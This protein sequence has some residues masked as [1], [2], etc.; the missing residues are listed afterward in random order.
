M[1]TDQLLARSALIG[2]LLLLALW[3]G[4]FAS[5]VRALDLSLGSAVPANALAS[6]PAALQPW[7]DWVLYDQQDRRC[8]VNYDAVD[9]RQC[10][11]PSAL[12][13]TL[14]ARGGQ[15]SQKIYTDRESWLI[16]PGDRRHWPQEVRLD[17]LLVPVLER[18]DRPAIK[19][20]PGA[21]QI[22]GRFVWRALPDSIRVPTQNALLELRIDGR[23]V[24]VSRIESDGVLWLR[25]RPTEPAQQDDLDLQVF[26]LLT[27][28]IP[29]EVET[30]LE[31]RVSGQ[32]REEMLGP[33]LLPDFLPLALN[34]PLPARLEPDGRLRVQ[35]RPGSWTINLTAR[36]RGPVDALARPTI[37]T[38]WPEQEIWSFRAQNALRV[39]QVSGA[40]ALDPA[41]TR[42]PEAWRQWPAYLV[43]PSEALRFAT[44]TRG[45]TESIPESLTLDRTLWL[46]FGGG[47]YTV[48]DRLS[49]NLNR[50]RL[51][52]APALKLGRVE[53]NG[54]DQF[55]TQS[56]DAGAT[57]VEVRRLN[58]LQLVAD[59]RLELAAASDL[60][61]VGWR[62]APQH[63]N[64]TLNLPPGWRLLAA[65][66]PDSTGNAWL[67]SWNL[68]DL[69]V[70]L[71]IAFGFGKLW[72][73]LWGIAALLGM[74]L[75]YHEPN[76][77]LYVWL[78]ILAA[79]ALLRVL[80]PGRFRVLIGVYRRL[81]LLALLVI[82]AL[83]AVQQVRSALY[84]QLEP[85]DFDEPPLIGLAAF[86][87]NEPMPQAVEE[88]QAY[89]RAPSSVVP[90]KGDRSK[91]MQQQYAPDIKVQ[92]GPGLP[93]WNWQRATLRWNGPV[94]AD[95]RLQLW[96]LPPWGTRLLLLLGLALLAAMGG[97]VFVAGQRNTDP[98]S[99]PPHDGAEPGDIGSPGA[100]AAV[101]SLL[102]AGL[103]LGAPLAARAEWPTPE[104]LET[105]RDRL[106]EPPDCQRCGDLAALAL[107]AKGGDL[108]L[109]L[110]LHA[111]VDTAVPLPLPRE[112][113]IVRAVELDG[114]AAILL[115]DPAQ[116]LWLRLPA[117]LHELTV[118]AAVPDAVAT[119][120]LPL[121]MAP[122]RVELDVEGW[123]VEGYIEGRADKQ[124][125]LTRQRQT[126]ATPLQA[127]VMP[128]FV[129][130]EREI[131]LDVDWQIRTRV[132]RL[133]QA[134]SA[135]V[136]EIPLLP[137]ERVTT[138]DVRVRDGR[139]LL[140]LPPDRA[141]AVWNATLSRSD[142]L[143]LKAAE[144]DDFVEVWQLRAGSLWH[145][146]STGIPLVQR[147]DAEGQWL[148]EWRPWPGEQVT[149]TI[150]RPEGAPGGTATI[151]RSQLQLN[152]GQRLSEAT[153]E[154]TVRASRG[155]DQTVT[156]PAGA[157]LTSVRVNDVQQP[158]QQ[159]GQQVVLPL[160][161]GVQ[162]IVLVWR[163]EQGIGTRYETPVVDLGSPSVNATLSVSLPRN[164]WVLLAG[165]PVMG[166]AVLFWG[167]L[168]VILV[169]AIVLARVGGTPL[170]VH[171]WFLL[172]VGLSQSHVLA[173][174]VVAGW[175][176]LLAR[177][178]HWAD[179]EMGTFKFDLAQLALALL[180]LVAGAVLLGAIEQGLLGSPD[181]QIAGNHSSAWQLN[182]YQ[183][184]VAG[185]LP[186]AW[187]MSAPML[188]Y[189][190]LMLA[191]ALWLALAI[192]RWLGWAWSCFSAGGLWRR[193]R[194][195]H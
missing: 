158:I 19:A 46:D 6:I 136:V 133:S 118:T 147:V 51:D 179:R 28:G 42:L 75:I 45:D 141:E 137:G 128:P 171:E 1:R 80:P 35:L 173:I 16:L 159:Q 59:S 102:L 14:D 31:L 39:V 71:V 27:D 132:R 86:L 125:Q 178:K 122:G 110:S 92:T 77:P 64:A 190:G 24:A 93:V 124:L 160:T 103:L 111:Q 90:R 157:I 57:G 55:I 109:R 36:H 5:P 47:G 26:R 151:D 108:T 54:E 131:V 15:F 113:L 98:A 130:V 186:T 99:Q 60:A 91:K 41:Q 44:R 56:S 68:L 67:Y 188:L 185:S 53:I 66:G 193:W 161:P 184:R 127:G 94:A 76:A 105:L 115:R 65:T 104:L 69:F 126:A 22:G 9:R 168:L 167:V 142:S 89:N 194:R 165:G 189:R 43:Q 155:A 8:P 174:L 175:L 153:L 116:L 166:P 152:P 87:P 20:P 97:R 164:R 85:F 38:P 192:L 79:V 74:A 120:Q 143:V 49:G 78:N 183:D 40:P 123:L 52:A 191:W 2:R 135:A 33:V 181:M 101:L 70:V 88:M 119:L 156:L 112:G 150:D 107:T 81:A 11:W 172:G 180:T 82:G 7:V 169:G 3:L 187:V 23:P 140:N 182:W 96:L 195:S 17:A 114:Q 61:T 148:P 95:E 34:S 146:Q 37:E 4:L 162:R 149:L 10:V 48:Q 145:V 138:P 62:V 72:G 12:Q 117:G 73:W 106:T 84:P 139:V 21:H 129:Q 154:M 100:A 83:F 18:D 144:R 32:A 50:T 121:P 134:D 177:R 29:F 13:L 163:S 170:R 63:V 30:R 25:Q 176:L 58:D